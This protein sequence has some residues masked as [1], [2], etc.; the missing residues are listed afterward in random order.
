M[1]NESSL[2]KRCMLQEVDTCFVIFAPYISWQK[3]YVMASNQQFVLSNVRG[4]RIAN[5]CIVVML[6]VGCIETNQVR[7]VLVLRDVRI[8]QVYIYSVRCD[9]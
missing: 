5:T 9:K 8:S 3:S 7:W 1:H 4:Y 2:K 6:D